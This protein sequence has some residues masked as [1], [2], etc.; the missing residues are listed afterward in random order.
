MRNTRHLLIVFCGAGLPLGSVAA[1]RLRETDLWSV[2][3]L[4]S[5]VAVPS[6][7]NEV[8]VKNPIDRFILARLRE[9]KLHPTRASADRNTLLRRLSFGLTGLPPSVGEIERFAS[10]RSKD[11]YERLVERLLDSPHYGERW[12]RHWLDV[13]RFG[14]SDGVL[15]VNE[16]KVRENAFKF[17]DAVIRAFNEDLPFDEFVRNHLH[18]PAGK[19]SD[20]GKF[21]ELRQFMHL[22]TRLQNNSDP[23]DKQFHRLDDMVSTTG[24]A[25]LGMTFGCARCH[26]HPVDPM[27]TEEYYQFTAFYFDQ[28]REAPQASRKRIELRI[29]EPRVLLNGSWKSPGKRVAPGF[30]QILMEKSDGHWRREGRSELEALG[31]WL[32]DAEAG[33]GELLAR[34]IV[35][36][37]WHHHFGQ[38]LV[39]TPNDFGALGEPPSHPDLLDYLAR[40]LISNKWRLKAIQRMIVESATYRQASSADS[41]FVAR[42]AENSLLWHRRP[43]R[44]EAEGIRDQLLMAAGVLRPEM[45]GPSISIGNYKTGVRDEP[46]SWRRSIY[47]QAHRSAKHPTLSLFN[48]ADSKRSVGARTTG[49]DPVGALFALNSKLGWDLAGRLAK[50]VEGEV[51]SDRRKQ[52]ERAYLL[53]LSRPPD[54]AE[55]KTAMSFLG[56]SSERLLTDFCHLLFGLNEFIYIN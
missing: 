22:G 12:A 42:D 41:A 48:P 17:R 52:A 37:L 5:P 28:F 44:L 15:T 38:G 50:R 32:T 45:F 33:A 54:E 3:P 6:V 51:G 9:N 49:A 36:R 18:G 26:D 4:P 16:D 23:N 55:L 53:T 14:E 13:V 31:A 35:N 30:L 11:A 43:Q 27:S 7:E 56:G 24:T 8:W 25:F 47:L 21:E 39:R 29:R 19:D 40:E 10:D 20:R 1:E 2:Q 34:V 46:K